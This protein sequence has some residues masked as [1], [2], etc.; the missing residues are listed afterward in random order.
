MNVA[1]T[2][3]LTTNGCDIYMASETYGQPGGDIV[4]VNSIFMD[5]NVGH[6]GSNTN[7]VDQIWANF[8]YT[9]NIYAAQ[10]SNSGGN[11][12]NAPGSGGIKT[13]QPTNLP[14]IREQHRRGS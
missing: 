11:K 1:I 13:E 3:D 5:A 8:V 7:R 6:I 10:W 9:K 12:P 4:N 2:Q 14:T